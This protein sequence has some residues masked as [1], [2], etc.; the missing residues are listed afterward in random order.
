MPDPGYAAFVANEAKLLALRLARDFH[1]LV[2]VLPPLAAAL[3]A[4]ADEA[5]FAG[6]AAAPREAAPWAFTAA[7][8]AAG[9]TA[10]S[11]AITRAGGMHTA[12]S[13]KLEK[14]F[15]G[16]GVFGRNLTVMIEPVAAA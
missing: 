5:A 2:V 13:R 12:S 3:G 7:I 4:K 14:R 16:R 1:G 8:V 11:P 10:E 15:G 9:V 6:L